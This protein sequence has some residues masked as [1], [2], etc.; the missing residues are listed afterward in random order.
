MLLLAFLACQDYRISKQ[1]DVDPVADTADTAPPED[2]A[3]PV[4]TAP[5]LD[6]VDTAQPGTDETGWLDTAPDTAPPID[7]APPDPEI[8]IEPV[9]VN[10]G[11][12]LYS[13][14]PKSKNISPIGNFTDGSTP[15]ENMTDIAI[16]LSGRMYGISFESLWRINPLSG[17]SSHIA[18]L[19]EDVYLDSLTFVSDGRLIAAG[20]GEVWLMDDASAQLTNLSF[21]TEYNSAG[22]I[23]G[24]PDGLLYWSVWEAGLVVV[25]PD[26]GS[27]RYLGSTEHDRIFGLGYAYGELWAFSDEGY[28]LVLNTSTGAPEQS[29]AI[30]TGWW[31]ATTN[32]V[33]W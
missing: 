26:D 14:D 4:D 3:P 25:D 30:G 15:I 22:D 10:S 20:N 32:P 9:Y 11:D 24:L 6:T 16:D 31:G 29:Y 5:P 23:V 2:T 19:G 21:T 17:A 27:N 1:P 33:L 8:A 13:F 7:T 12:T 28:A 18:D